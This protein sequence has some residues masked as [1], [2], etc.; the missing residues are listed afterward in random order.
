MGTVSDQEFSPKGL[1]RLLE[2]GE[3]NPRLEAF[4]DRYDSDFSNGVLIPPLQHQECNLCG[5][6]DDPSEEL[7]DEGEEYFVVEAETKKGHDVRNML[8]NR[9]DRRIPSDDELQNYGE[10]AFHSLLEETYSEVKGPVVVYAGMN[11]F[12]HPHL[13]AGDLEILESEESKV[14]EINNYIVF[15][16]PESLEDSVV[17]NYGDSIGEAYLKRF[18]ETTVENV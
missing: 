7:L 5:I 10:E 18:Y 12:T 3:S 8:V 1:E 2:E 13:L 16:G 6:P 11:T 9:D 17:E 14:E 15:E 4:L